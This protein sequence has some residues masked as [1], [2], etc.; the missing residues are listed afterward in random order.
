MRT[1][2]PPRRPRGEVRG[3][4]RAEIDAGHRF[5]NFAAERSEDFVKWHLDGHDYMWPSPR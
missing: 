2:R 5:D 1:H 3:R 4:V